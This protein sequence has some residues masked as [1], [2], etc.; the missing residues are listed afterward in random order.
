M[1]AISIANQ[2][3]L[4]MKRTVK[5]TVDGIKYRLFRA[6]VTVAVITLAVAFL[7]N[8][9]AESLIKRAIASNTRERIQTSRRVYD[10]SARLSSPGGH[11]SVIAEIAATTTDSPLYKETQKFAG[12][13]D[14]QMADFQVQTQ[15]ITFILN[16][17]NSLDYAKRRTMIH[18]AQGLGILHRLQDPKS[19]ELFQTALSRIKSIHFDMSMEELN[20]ILQKNNETKNIVDS[21]LKART[22]A[23]A[24]V[25][26]QLGNKTL[27]AALA[28]S[29][30][31][32]GNVIREAGFIFDH[33][34]AENEVA[35]QAK[36]LLDTLRIE[37]SMEVR[38]TRMIPVKEKA[39][40]GTETT[41]TGKKVEFPLRQLIAQH[42]NVLPA[43]VNVVM[44]WKYMESKNFASKYLER[45][46][47]VDAL[48]A[49]YLTK[50]DAA[51]KGNEAVTVEGIS[52][53]EISVAGLSAERMVDLARSRTETAALLK[54][55]RL[56]MDAGKGFMGLGERLAW[57][58]FVSMLVCGIGITNAMMMA[59]T[60]RFTE[61]ATLKCLGALDG[62]IM[63]MF[64]LESCFM[65]L[66]GGLAGAV[67][68]SVI[69]LGRM[70]VSFGSNF[71]TAIPVLDVLLGMLASILL[72]TALAAIAA[73]VPS[74]KAARLA[75][76]EAMRVE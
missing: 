50:T 14:S 47:E 67:I 18:T 36:R 40:N 1:K 5:I 70:M 7:M 51:P 53:E 42:A 39:A 4:S 60:E 61:I 3:W 24:K 55:E 9:L 6:S 27:L 33:K 31:N 23:I 20:D 63:I 43:D 44:M 46:K 56:T 58:L 19:M 48:A 10:W 22:N 75:P 54:A 74:F 28:E 21:I 37:K 41:K 15:K 35:P 17:F 16:F 49:K 62:F 30:K 73:V 68:G 66:V 69:G 13:T 25:S 65:G 64:V 34:M 57:L 12:L 32:F 11:E 38:L 72:G 26:S 8:I 2:P 29:D 71:F 76:M 45:M 59:V 52:S